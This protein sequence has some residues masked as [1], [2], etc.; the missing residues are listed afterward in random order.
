MARRYNPQLKR[1][2][3]V[4]VIKLIDSQVLSPPRLFFAVLEL[5]ALHRQMTGLLL[6]SRA[7][8]AVRNRA[9]SGQ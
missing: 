9:R 8:L 2:R 4:V 3:V 6:Y 7:G 5:A 1:E